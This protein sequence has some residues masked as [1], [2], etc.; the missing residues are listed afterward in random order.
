MSAPRIATTEVEKVDMTLIDG[1]LYVV[2]NGNVYE[3]DDLAE[4]AGEYVGRLCGCCSEID[5]D[6]DES[7]ALSALRLEVGRV[8]AERLAERQA[9]RDREKALQAELEAIRA[10]RDEL[11]RLCRREAVAHRELKRQIS[12][13]AETLGK[14]AQ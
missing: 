9:A 3:Y 5:T 11:R 2:R 10:E 12:K 6:A 13:Q 4:K 1:A 7:T 8:E 14:L